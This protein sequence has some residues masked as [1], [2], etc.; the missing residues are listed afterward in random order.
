MDKLRHSLKLYSF[1]ARM[2]VVLALSAV[3]AC[4][5]SLLCSYALVHYNL[6]IEMTDTQ[7]KTAI[8]LMELEQKTDLSLDE[9]VS[10][11]DEANLQL[12]VL[13]ERDNAL[14]SASE[15]DQLETRTILTVLGGIN[16][17][18][19]TYVQMRENVVLIA[20]KPRLTL[21][22]TSFWRVATLGAAFLTVFVLISAITAWRIA[23]PVSQITAATKRISE[24][25]FTI[26]LP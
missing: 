14:L 10:M 25:D 11:I 4:L 16:A 9:I 6:R 2:Q 12:F 20:A 3:I 8:H 24:G 15:L 23:K 1:R 22:M 26:K 5:I 18:P 7:Y 21:V 19:M 13:S 17:M